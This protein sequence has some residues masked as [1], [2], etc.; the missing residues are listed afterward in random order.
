MSVQ[1]EMRATLLGFG[2][3][4][5][6]TEQII[7]EQTAAAARI[8]RQIEAR[9][10]RTAAAHLVTYCPDH[11]SRDTCFMSCQCLGADELRRMA[12]EAGEQA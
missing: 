9:A 7:A 8:R 11:G 2:A 6:K 3:S 5:E 12:T 4:P 1:D 10:L